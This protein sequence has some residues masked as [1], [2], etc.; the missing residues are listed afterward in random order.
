MKIIHVKLPEE[1]DDIEEVT[2]P[3]NIT[4]TNDNYK[5]KQ[6]TEIIFHPIKYQ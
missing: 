1:F 3:N 5:E 6:N 2:F 4:F